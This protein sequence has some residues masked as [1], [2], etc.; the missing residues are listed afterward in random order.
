M[1][2][3]LEGVVEGAEEVKKER[4][5]ARSR[6]RYELVERDR[7]IAALRSEIASRDAVAA[8]EVGSTSR[9]LE[10]ERQM[11]EVRLEAAKEL[12]LVNDQLAGQADTISHLREHHR[13]VREELAAVSLSAQQQH[14]AF[15]LEL[16]D[17]HAEVA[18][19]REELIEMERNRTATQ[20]DLDETQERLEAV[21]QE[22]DRLVDE[23][24]IK[25]DKLQL[26]SAAWEEH[27]SGMAQLMESIVKNE[28][29]AAS[30]TRALKAAEEELAALRSE[31]NV[32]IEDRDRRLT[33]AE[34]SLSSRIAKNE[35]LVDE[36][37]RL[38][39]SIH[40]LRRQSADR[41]GKH[42]SRSRS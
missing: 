40:H 34:T 14:H 12:N 38:K 28:S 8:G 2:L 42:V 13:A 24:R 6:L 29:D 18:R 33:E 26:Q 20:D 30:K 31:T 19:L 37:N 21:E 27:Q 41:E 3:R 32:L 16:V 22:M 17:A 9:D 10:V 1:R 5:D 15:D 35:A 39:E 4:D 25:D 36:C 7:V 11:D 23:G